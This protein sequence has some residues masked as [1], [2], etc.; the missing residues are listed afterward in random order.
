MIYNTPKPQLR[1]FLKKKLLP[2]NKFIV[3]LSV[4]VF[5]ISSSISQNTPQGL[6]VQ[7]GN[8]IIHSDY[9]EGNSSDVNALSV[10]LTHSLYFFGIS[11]WRKQNTLNHHISL[12]SELNFVSNIK[13][14]HKGEYVNGNG[15]L[16]TQLR[17][18]TGSF[19]ITN[20]GFQG[21]IY[22]KNLKEFIYYNNQYGTN[23]N[24]YLLAGIQFSIFKNSLNSTLGDWTQDSSVLPEKWRDPSDTSVGRGT[25][26]SSTF[27]LGTR[28]KL[29]NE[30]DLNAQFKWQFFFSDN[31]D[32]LRSNSP[33]NE[34]NE[35]S[36]VFQ[37]GFIYNLF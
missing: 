8:S 18:M 34:D 10:S 30:I 24:P 14:S 13:L 3:I 33:E 1:A 22:L 9:G 23:L 37:I 36:T 20:I 16:A 28:Y 6:G 27:G 2:K 31:L 21:E 7:I 11:S 15:N 29:N 35:W 32:G 5:N 25:S 4:I 12:R 26:F 19:K 17:A